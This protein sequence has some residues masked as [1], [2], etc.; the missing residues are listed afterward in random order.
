MAQPCYVLSLHSLTT[1]GHTETPLLAT[2]DQLRVEMACQT[3]ERKEEKTWIIYTL[4][5]ILVCSNAYTCKN[6]L[7]PVK[8]SWIW[9]EYIF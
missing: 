4:M 7:F 3:E 1:R 5:Y 9:L 2:H 8:S 6:H